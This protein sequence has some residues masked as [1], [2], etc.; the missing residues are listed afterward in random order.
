MVIL[1][2]KKMLAV[3]PVDEDLGLTLC[4]ELPGK[5]GK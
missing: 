1:S 4:I 3:E 2:Q 5:S